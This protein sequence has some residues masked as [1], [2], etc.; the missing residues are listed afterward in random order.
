MTHEAGGVTQVVERLPN[1]HE[2]LSSKPC[3]DKKKRKKKEKKKKEGRK[4]QKRRE[5]KVTKN[6][7]THY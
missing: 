3:T 2:V 4:K 7:K 1:K 5:K 6:H